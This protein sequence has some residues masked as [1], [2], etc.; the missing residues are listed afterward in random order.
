MGIFRA[1]DEAAQE[2]ILGTHGIRF[3]ALDG[4]IHAIEKSNRLRRRRSRRRS[5]KRLQENP[6]N[7]AEAVHLAE[8][9]CHTHTEDVEC[10]V[11]RNSMAA[12]FLEEGLALP[13]GS[14]HDENERSVLSNSMA[15][16][17][18]E[19]GLALPH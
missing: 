6:T 8:C 15:A 17:L 10:S 3:S 12:G 5:T 19:E 7:Q 2:I 14:M 1:G 11:L 18:L 9:M 4:I 13:P 16:G